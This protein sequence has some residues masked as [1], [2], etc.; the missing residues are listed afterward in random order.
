VRRA[1]AALSAGYGLAATAHATTVEKFVY[2]L[3]G[4]PLRVPTA[5]I[6]AIN[7]VLLLDAW[8]EHD[9]IHREAA[10]LAALAPAAG[11]G[12]RLD[13]L[14]SRPARRQ[15]LELSVDAAGPCFTQ[16]GGDRARLRDEVTARTALLGGLSSASTNQSLLPD[17]VAVRLGELGARWLAA[18][19]F[20]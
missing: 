13:V 8:R 5:E 20:E 4:Y 17:E 3:A 6:A 16:L 14:A 1:L 2:A 19:N 18:P 11:G 9:T 10:H 12:V 7:L 15:P